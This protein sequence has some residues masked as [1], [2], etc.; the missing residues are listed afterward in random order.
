MK[1]AVALFV[2]NEA[3]DIAAWIAWHFAI[4]IDKLFIYDDH[5]QDGTYEI[6]KGASEIFDIELTRSDKNKETNFYWR[7]RDSYFDACRKAQ[8]TYDW[9]GFIDADEYISLEG[10]G[11]ISAF[12]RNFLESNAVALSWRIYGSSSRVVKTKLGI[13]EAYNHHSTKE[14]DDNTLVKSFV[15]PDKMIFHYENPHK[16]TVEGDLYVDSLGSK[17]EWNGAC[18]QVI[19]E[20]ACINHYICRSME[21]YVDRIKRRLGVDLH[22]STVYWDHFNRNDLFRTENDNFINS[23]NKNLYKIKE[24]CVS[25]YISNFRGQNT[26]YKN[27]PDN[28]GFDVFSLRK[29][30]GATLCLNNKEGHLT[31]VFDGGEIHFN[32]SALIYRDDPKYVYLFSAAGEHI[33][34]VPFHISEDGRF[35]SV[36]QFLIET[37]EHDQSIHYL[38]SPITDKYLTFLPKDNSGGVACDREQASN[39]E[40]IC[41]V[42]KDKS[43]VKLNSSPKDIRSRFDFFRDVADLNKTIGYNDFMVMMSCLSDEEIKLISGLEHGRIIGWIL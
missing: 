13:Y 1:T 2:K 43:E 5:S 14:L 12:L 40:E 25:H 32:L 9:I 30:S 3:Q 37:N 11:D 38:K 23:A 41:F 7:Q 17:V 20:N 4:G 42:K 36:Y 8:G 19:W 39:W 15:R 10:F 22:N 6:V 21:N 33:S 28:I 31:Q 24:R 29:K 16:F 18:K 35:G 27:S 34:N 26:E